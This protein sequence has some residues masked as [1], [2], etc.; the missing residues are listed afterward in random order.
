MRG[1]GGLHMQNWLVNEGCLNMRVAHL[2]KGLFP[3]KNKPHSIISRAAS[4]QLL[5]CIPSWIHL[6]ITPLLVGGDYLPPQPPR[7]R[8]REKNSKINLTLTIP[9]APT[10]YYLQDT[11]TVTVKNPTDERSQPIK[12]PVSWKVT[13]GRTLSSELKFPYSLIYSPN[14][15]S[16]Y[17]LDF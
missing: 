17:F 14:F 8:L 1:W 11:I 3:N 15:D 16:T 2:T 4:Y 7:L 12:K 5:I 13:V 6:H 9:V 10:N